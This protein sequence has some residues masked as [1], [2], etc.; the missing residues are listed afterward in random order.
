MR[1]LNVVLVLLVSFTCLMSFRFAQKFDLK[2]SNER[3][4]EVYN[5]QCITCHMEKGEGIE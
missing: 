4:K 1:K 3:G 2:A 5:A